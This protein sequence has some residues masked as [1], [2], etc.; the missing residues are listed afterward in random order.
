MNPLII[1]AVFGLPMISKMVA[2]NTFYFGMYRGTPLA[3]VPEA[4][5]ECVIINHG[6]HKAVIA[7][8]TELAKRGRDIIVCG[9]DKK[10]LAGQ[11]FEP[12]EAE[13]AIPSGKHKG[14]LLSELSDAAVQGMWSSWNGINKLKVSAFFAEI[15]AEKER[16]NIKPGTKGV[17]SKGKKAKT[18]PKTED[19]H[20]NW[21]D[22]NGAEHMIPNEVSMEGR[23][24]EEAPF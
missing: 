10:P 18:K 13:R 19:Q 9:K 21:K 6:D 17:S 4:Y 2:D 23:E 5:C 12:G 14:K 7:A 15:E 11:L 3:D 8:Q 16:R 24:N 22:A 1:L 20:Y